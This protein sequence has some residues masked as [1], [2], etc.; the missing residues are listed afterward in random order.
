MSKSDM[1]LKYKVFSKIYDNLFYL[2][3][4]IVFLNEKIDPRAALDQKI[5][6]DNLRILDVCCGT[7][8]DSIAIAK[9]SS[10]PLPPR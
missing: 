2:L 10:L 6:N 3:E 9:P 1:I 4:K 8:R 5:P 7:G